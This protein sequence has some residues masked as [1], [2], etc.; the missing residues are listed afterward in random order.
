MY[1][2]QNNQH[3]FFL[4]VFVWE[5]GRNFIGVMRWAPSI[6]LISLIKATTPPEGSTAAPG[7]PG[8]PPSVSTLSVHLAAQLE[9]FLLSQ[10]LLRSAASGSDFMRVVRPLL[11]TPFSSGEVVA[12]A[13]NPLRP[14]STGKTYERMMEQKTSTKENETKQTEAFVYLFKR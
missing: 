5:G 13:T 3:C 14:A 7:V 2:P 11:P 8:V 4:G 10:L 12:M 9:S 1:N 6:L